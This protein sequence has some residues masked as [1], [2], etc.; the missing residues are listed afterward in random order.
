LK[1]GDNVEVVTAVPATNPG[2]LFRGGG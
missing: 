1:P 2:G